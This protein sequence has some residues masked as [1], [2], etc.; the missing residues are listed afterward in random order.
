MGYYYVE[1]IDVDQI[2]LSPEESKHLV[3]V[4]RKRVGDEVLFTNGKG[5]RV[6]AQ[7][8]IAEKDMCVAEVLERETNL[9]KRTK[10]LHIAVAP[11]KNPDRM[12]WFVEK[13]VE[14]G[15]E[16]ITFLQCERSERKKIDLDRMKRIAVAAL[17]Q[18]SAIYLPDF[19]FV[20]FSDFFN[21]I[22][23]TI[24]D[25]Y[26]AHCEKEDSAIQWIN[27]SSQKSWV[28]LLIGPE[29]DFSP[30]EIEKAR[31]EG[32]CEV[33]LG[34]KIL[35]TETAALYGVAVFAARELSW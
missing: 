32:F 13:A 3:K 20:T 17:K 27:I 16:K 9:S 30:Q 10:Q 5:E 8:T 1:N 22:D 35:R 34:N 18:S 14:M 26:I 24:T 25:C 6:R 12:E 7:I 28:L 15:I 19:D 23:K 2:V 31:T 33:K 4:L 21:G 29:G 11:T